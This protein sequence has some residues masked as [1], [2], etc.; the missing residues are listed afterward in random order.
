MKLREN[1]LLVNGPA[2]EWFGRCQPKPGDAGQSALQH[3][4]LHSDTENR[5]QDV[6]CHNE[7]SDFSEVI[8][9]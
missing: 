1:Y 9:Q 8:D 4:D 6:L 5:L 7:R 2:N 3:P